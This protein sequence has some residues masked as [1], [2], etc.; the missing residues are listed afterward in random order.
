MRRPGHG[1]LD[2]LAIEQRARGPSLIQELSDDER[3]QLRRDRG[4]IL[5]SQPHQDG[6][7]AVGLGRARRGLRRAQASLKHIQQLLQRATLLLVGVERGPDGE[8]DCVID[9]AESLWRS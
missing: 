7:D 8:A 4:L 2:V 5:P 3:Q 1:G 6:C 9:H